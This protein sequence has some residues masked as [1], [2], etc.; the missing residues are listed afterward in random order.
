MS[1]SVV[2]MISHLDNDGGLSSVSLAE[3]GPV[4]G[5]HH[6]LE[7]PAGLVVQLS[8]EV[9]LPSLPPR[10]DSEVLIDLIRLTRRQAVHHLAEGSAV[11]VLSQEGGD[12]SVLR[13]AVLQHAD[14]PGWDL[15]KERAVVVAVLHQYQHRLGDEVVLP[16]LPVSQSEQDGELR[17]GLVVQLPGEVEVPRVGVPAHHRH[18]A[19]VAP[20]HSE[21]KII[22]V[23]VISSQPANDLD[24]LQ[25]LISQKLQET[26]RM[27]SHVWLGL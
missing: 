1:S 13:Q 11:P 22:S 16:E 24:F 20:R 25:N 7:Q 14:R 23:R 4:P 18:Q 19:G 21:L 2:K 27:S 10:L 15:D 6:H 26:L 5:L 8:L 17:L 12:D 9:E 3:T